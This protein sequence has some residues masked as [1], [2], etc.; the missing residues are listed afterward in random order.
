[1]IDA[2]DV[3]AWNVAPR[4]LELGTDAVHVWRVPLV[5]DDAE[6]AV[7]AHSLSADERTR[8][9][10]FYFERDRRSFTV[11]RGALRTVLGRY[12]DVPAAAI[13][14][15]YRERG[16]PYLAAPADRGVQFNLSHS[17]D[18]ALIAVTRQRELGVDV[19]Q[20]RP[21]KDLLSLAHTS[22][23]PREYAV[24]RSLPVEQHVHAFFTCWS[25][26]EAF[27]KATGE[28]VAQL[29]DFDVSL[30]PGEPAQIL[31]IRDAARPHAWQLHA[32][33]DIPD[34]AA[35]L[36]VAR[37]PSHEPIELACWRWSPLL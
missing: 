20:R 5:P 22:F 19:E 7:L 1:M 10:K 21:I 14:F 27:I 31:W 30:R 18:F 26:K 24:F 33:P 36:V 2:S 23:S 4:A 17:G 12:L 28:G 37:G 9:S 29:A 8:A 34:H 32:L 35:A 15:A 16:K 6:V 11:A 13:G 25:R 3:D